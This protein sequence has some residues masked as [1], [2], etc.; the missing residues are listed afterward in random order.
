MNFIIKEQHELAE[1]I[2]KLL[3][4]TKKLPIARRTRDF[5]NNL[6]VELDE[7]WTT[8]ENNDTSIRKKNPDLTDKYFVDDVYQSTKSIYNNAVE[9]INKFLEELNENDENKSKQSTTENQ[10]DKNAANINITRKRII[11]RMNQLEKFIL[12]NNESLDQRQPKSHYEI[13]IKKL[14][15]MVDDIQ[16]KLEDL[17]VFSDDNDENEI[18]KI[19]EQIDIIME[20][21]NNTISN[22]Q[23]ISEN[24]DAENVKQKPPKLPPIKI[25]VFDGDFKKWTA[26]KNLF[27]NVI[28]ENNILSNVEKLRYL[29]TH[30]INE[31]YKLIHHLQLTNENYESAFNLIINR[32]D[33]HRKIADMYLDILLDLPN[34]TIKSASSI[35]VL[36]DSIK[37]C[38]EGMKS[39][40]TSLNDVIGDSYIITRIGIKKLDPESLKVFEEGL[41]EPKKSPTLQYFLKFLESRFLVLDSINEKRSSRVGSFNNVVENTKKCNLCQGDHYLYQCKQFENM[42]IAERNKYIKRKKLCQNCISHNAGKKCHK[43][44]S[45][46]QCGGK[47][48]TLL[49]YNKKAPTPDNNQIALTNQTNSATAISQNQVNAETN[50]NHVAQKR[51]IIILST[52]LIK[53]RS[54]SGNF[55]Y[56]RALIDQG[57]QVSLITEEAAQLLGLPRT[58]SNIE[59]SG[60]GVSKQKPCNHKI[61]IEI[62]PYFSNTSELNVTVHI[63]KKITGQIPIEPINDNKEK[64]KNLVLADPNYDSPGKIDILLGADVFSNLIVKGIKIGNPT[65]V[66]TKLGWILNGMTNTVRHSNNVLSHISMAEIHE[67][68]KQFWEIDESTITSTLNEAELHFQ[69]NIR[70]LDNGRYEVSL[71][72]KN[73]EVNLGSSRKLALARLYQV[74][75]TLQKNPH[76]QQQYHSFMKEYLKLGHMK[77]IKHENH[78]E[79][80]YLPHHDVWRE[81][82]TTLQ[83][84]GIV[85]LKPGCFLKQIGLTIAARNTISSTI[86]SNFFPLVN[87]EQVI[88]HLEKQDI[89]GFLISPTDVKNK[90]DSLQKM[91]DH[92]RI[93]EEKSVLLNQHNMHH[94]TMIYLLMAAGIISIL[95]LIIL[96]RR[97]MFNIHDRLGIQIQPRPALQAVIAPENESSV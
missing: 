17:F 36:H 53:I 79:G 54:A 11:F 4:N 95:T 92:Q 43:K 63:I 71:P 56:C 3:A 42:A 93:T 7:Y 94:Y 26:F 38:I 6:L 73:S 78:N 39:L 91:V 60:V 16:Q 90:L 23:I 75:N 65:A 59:I 74:E 67:S 1:K 47:H 81:E 25:P 32:Y 20:K 72:F 86:E 84:Q 35:K 64:W 85:H 83:G 33:N 97:I 48:N 8:F 12:T 34:A 62:R 41:D 31:P 13:T 45:C 22:L 51:N 88:S 44:L 77:K 66:K 87:S 52:A 21:T 57:S 82:S 58:I 46:S 28:H 24:K 96:Y 68:M 2:A 9:V 69:S 19:V 27:Y 49:H 55:E 29:Q 70:R 80:Y 18:G 61:N 37:E 5:L 10:D 40:N 14:Q 30:L 15:L 76:K 89:K 50:V